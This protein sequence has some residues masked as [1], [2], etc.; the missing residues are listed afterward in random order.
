[1][2]KLIRKRVSVVIVNDGKI[3]GFYAED[4]FSKRKYFFLP[5]GVLEKNESDEQ[6]AIRET[7]EET[8]YKIT[9]NDKKVVKTYD[10][11]WNGNI[12]ECETRFFLGKLVSTEQNFVKDAD[13]HRGT[14]WIPL[15]Q[16]RNV[17]GY[18]TEILSA[19]SELV[20]A[21]A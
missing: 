9:L 15:N 8:G 7:L 6:A 21:Q 2:L 3:L 5:G 14:S 20:G 1:M 10:F 4:P 18:S 19:T 16:I 11:E 13:Y 17:L 12:Y